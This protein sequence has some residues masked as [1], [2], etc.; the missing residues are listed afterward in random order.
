MT[1]VEV[2]LSS[3]SIQVRDP[4]IRVITLQA[5][6]SHNSEARD[7]TVGTPNISLIRFGVSLV[8][9]FRKCFRYLIRVSPIIVVLLVRAVVS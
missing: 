8:A 3:L 5:T 9:Q 1:C 2:T 6:V 7:F 4:V